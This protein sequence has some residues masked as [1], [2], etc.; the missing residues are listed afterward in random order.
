MTDNKIFSL[1]ECHPK[2]QYIE[3]E[4]KVGSTRE[5]AMEF[6]QIEMSAKGKRVRLSAIAVHDKDII[7]TGRL[8]RIASIR[9]EGWLEDGKIDDPETIISKIKEAKAGADLFTFEQVVPHCEPKFDYY[10]EWDNFAVLP[11]TTFDHWWTKQVN[12]KTR[13]MVRRA[14]K[15]GVEVRVCAFEEAMVLGISK[16]YDETPIRQGRKFWHYRKGLDLVRKENSS[17]LERSEFIGAYSGQDLIGF[18]KLV[19]MGEV[20]GIMQILSMVKE[21]DKAPNNALVAKAVELCAE[22][23]VRYLIYSKFTYGKKGIDP[24]A[25]FKKHNA[26]QKMEVPR[27]YVPLNW[28]GSVGLKLGLHHELKEQLPES[29]A[30]Y[31]RRTREK[32]Y[33]WKMKKAVEG[34]KLGID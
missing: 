22:K 28:K 19:Y 5:E 7:I 2:K 17:F 34:K 11:I 24:L 10:M 27:Y 12:D 8:I 16:I 33:I 30:G 6:G 3:D 21:R 25:D 13:N 9:G 23:G 26:F 32:W 4:L 31:L 29:I 20:A 15:K 1:T 18:I 14:Q